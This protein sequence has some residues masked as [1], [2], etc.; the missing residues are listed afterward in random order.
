MIPTPIYKDGFVYVTS[1][2]GAGCNCFQITSAGGKFSAQQIYANKVM[3]NHHGG[4]LLVEGNVYG[5]SDGKGWTCQ[6]F[7]TGDAKWQDKEKLGKGSITYA[8]KRLYLRQEDKAG[9]VALIE[10]SPAGYKEHGRFNPANRSEKQSW[11]HPVVANGKLY[12]RDQNVLSCYDVKA[13]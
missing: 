3:V 2:Y 10:P 4:A 5:Y 1:G 8:D 7:K 12:L 9:S 13:R 6:D 11:P